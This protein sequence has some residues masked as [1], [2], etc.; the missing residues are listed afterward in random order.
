MLTDFTHLKDF[1]F[2]YYFHFQY[3]NNEFLE[4]DFDKME[5]TGM[6]TNIDCQK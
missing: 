6:E 4:K 5:R 3:G 1:D 2:W